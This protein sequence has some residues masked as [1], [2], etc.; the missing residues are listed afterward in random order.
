MITKILTGFIEPHFFAGFSGG[1]KGVL[2]SIAGA[3]SVLTNHGAKMIGHPNS[4]WGITQGNPIW[5]EMLEVARL[6]EPDFLFNVSLNRDKGITGVFCGSLE[7]AH[8][9]ARTLLCWPPPTQALRILAAQMLAT[10]DD[11]LRER[12]RAYKDGLRDMVLAKK[13]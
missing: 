12:L 11:A 7:A 9:A 5:E 6:T 8:E 4:T 13:I 2:P 3:D 10:A 1:P